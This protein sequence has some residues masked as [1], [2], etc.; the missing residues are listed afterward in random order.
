[1][2]LYKKIS[3]VFADQFLPNK[4][5]KIMRYLLNEENHILH[6]LKA[7]AMLL[8]NS[9]EE[10]FRIQSESRLLDLHFCSNAYKLGMWFGQIT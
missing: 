9:T 4:L 7:E 5:H 8:R 2:Y 1:M 10:Q 6:E 3:L